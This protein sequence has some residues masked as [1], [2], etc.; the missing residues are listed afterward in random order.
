MNNE[1]LAKMK[2]DAAAAL[3]HLPEFLT[4]GRGALFVHEQKT[5]RA[6]LISVEEL[7][8]HVREARTAIRAL[9]NKLENM[10]LRKVAKAKNPGAKK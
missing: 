5:E 9:H 8:A 2:A 6:V 1:A 3:E 4:D 7:L 10:P